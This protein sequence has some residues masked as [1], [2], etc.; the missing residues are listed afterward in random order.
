MKTTRIPYLSASLLWL[1]FL[2]SL[3]SP[4]VGAD[5]GG[6]WIA[7]QRSGDGAY[8]VANGVSTDYQSTADAL[9]TAVRL[10]AALQLDIPGALAY[11]NTQEYDGT[12][13]LARRIVALS[14]NGEEVS[15]LIQ[16][17]IGYQDDWEGGFGEFSGHQSTVPGAAHALEA[18]AAA[19]MTRSEAAGFGVDCLL[20]KQNQNGGWSYSGENASSAFLTAQ[21]LRVL[22]RYQDRLDLAAALAAGQEF[23]LA[24]RAAWRSAA[25]WRGWSPTPE[26][27]LPQPL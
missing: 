23:L 12:E 8:A 21:S 1:V 9:R 15:L 7:A 16:Q 24:A 11:L 26:P 6:T 5:S 13:Y 3:V 4:S 19:G 18:L 27:R 25:A 10:G 20:Q 17:L 14:D 2:F 22:A